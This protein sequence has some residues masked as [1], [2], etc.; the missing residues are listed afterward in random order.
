MKRHRIAV[1]VGSLRQNSYNGRLAD[2]MAAM[3]SDQFDFDRIR[4]DDLPLYN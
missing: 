3:G 4:F 2:T 1:M